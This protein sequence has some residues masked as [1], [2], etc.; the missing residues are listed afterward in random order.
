MTARTKSVQFCLSQNKG[1][2]NASWGVLYRQW[3]KFLFLFN[4][5][6]KEETPEEKQRIDAEY[7]L[8]NTGTYMTPNQERKSS[9]VTKFVKNCLKPVRPTGDSSM[10][11]SLK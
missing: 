9:I 10:I 7:M 4:L 8:D 6:Q 11:R 2:K 5:E 1:K 3:K